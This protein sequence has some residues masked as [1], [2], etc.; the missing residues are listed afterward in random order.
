MEN[1]SVITKIRRV[2]LAK[3]TSGAIE[4]ISPITKMAFGNGGVDENG[5]VIVPNEEQTSLNNQIGIYDIDSVSYPIE[6]MARYTVTIP[7]NELVGES[8]S[9]IALV[10][11]AGNLCA[12][13]NTLP[14]GKDNGVKF[15]FE[16]DDE[17]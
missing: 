8:I 5:N 3:I 14:K 16:F 9:E 10:D 12:I 1:T 15:T 6:T 17:F 4:S 11:S 2:N 7:E 13:K